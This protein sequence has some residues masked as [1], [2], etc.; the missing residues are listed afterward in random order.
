MEVTK[1]CKSR[2]E[3][4]RCVLRYGTLG[5]IGAAAGGTAVKRRRL[6][7]E[8]KCINDG[9]CRDCRV[10]DSCDR[11]AALSAKEVMGSKSNG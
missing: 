1:K 8:G 4:M 5:L 10:F 11:P 2:R 3:L 7:R 6:Y 9:L